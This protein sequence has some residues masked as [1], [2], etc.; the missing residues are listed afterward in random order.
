VTDDP[1]TTRKSVREFSAGGV[2]L[3]RMRGQWHVATIEPNIV[4]ADSITRNALKQRH[5]PAILALPKGA[6]DKGEKPEES[7]VREVLEETG[8]LVQAITKLT[9]IKYFYVRSWGGRERV[10]KV[11]TFFL[12]RYVSGRIGEIQPD[13]R[14]EVR[15]AIWLPLDQAHE[16]LTYPGERQVAQIARKYVRAHP[17]L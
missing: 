13:M 6:I 5:R 15:R 9:D 11:V 4:N 14:K 7:A 17:E 12:F 16:K 1:P 2:V 10:F 3:R 8:V